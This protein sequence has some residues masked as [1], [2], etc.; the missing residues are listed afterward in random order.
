MRIIV[1]WNL[2]I[3]LPN[4]FQ[5]PQIQWWTKQKSLP[6]QNLVYV[7]LVPDAKQSALCQLFDGFLQLLGVGTDIIHMLQMRKLSFNKKSCCK[8]YIAGICHSQEPN[9]SASTSLLMY[10][11]MSAMTISAKANCLFCLIWK[12]LILHLEFYGFFL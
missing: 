4:E 10:L 6:S 2:F 3:Q 12:H 11:R 5:V 1:S 7:I 8:E 9:Q